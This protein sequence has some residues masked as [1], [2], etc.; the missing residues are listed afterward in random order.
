MHVKHFLK[1][2]FHVIFMVWTTTAVWWNR[3]NGNTIFRQGISPT[4]STSK[5]SWVGIA[6]TSLRK[7]NPRWYRQWMICLGTT[8]LNFSRTSGTHM[9]E[10]VG[11][12]FW[13]CTGTRDQSGTDRC[14]PQWCNC[15]ATL[16]IVIKVRG[17]FVAIHASPLLYNCIHKNGRAIAQAFTDIRSCKIN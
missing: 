3:C 7:S 2:P 14:L 5:R 13:S 11:R 1:S 6:S 10:P 8:F 16:I 12:W 4:W 17:S 9:S 15:L